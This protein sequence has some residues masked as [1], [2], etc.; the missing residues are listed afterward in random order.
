[1]YLIYTLHPASLVGPVCFGYVHADVYCTFECSHLLNGI[2]YHLN[3]VSN[4]PVTKL[5]YYIYAGAKYS[6]KPQVICA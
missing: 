3:P 6:V 1:M 2:Y 5:K 4:R